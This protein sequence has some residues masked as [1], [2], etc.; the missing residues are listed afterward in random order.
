MNS[1]PTLGVTTRGR[2]DRQDFFD[3]DG[4]AQLSEAAQ[5][6]ERFFHGVRREQPGRLHL[7]PEA[8]DNLLIEDW[9]EAARPPS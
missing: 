3:P 6:R 1:G 4:L 7:A 5:G 2:G 8:G 9:R